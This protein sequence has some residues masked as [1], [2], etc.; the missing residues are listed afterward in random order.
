MIHESEIIITLGIQAHGP[1]VTQLLWLW[2]VI[3][4]SDPQ[5]DII[6]ILFAISDMKGTYIGV[7]FVALLGCIKVGICIHFIVHP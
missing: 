3:S 7:V 5:T 2:T 4:I 6:Y 1:Y